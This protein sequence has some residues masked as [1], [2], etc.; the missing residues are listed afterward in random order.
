MGS[1]NA[2]KVVVF[3][4]ISPLTDSFEQIAFTHEQAKQMRDAIARIIAPTLDLEKEDQEF[5]IVT[6]DEMKILLPNIRDEYDEQF[7]K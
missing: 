3:M 2:T 7:F 5:D 1:I 4:E 6:N